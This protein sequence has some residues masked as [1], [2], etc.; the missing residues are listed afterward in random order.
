MMTY[1]NITY[2]DHDGID[3][4]VHKWVPENNVTVKGSLCIVHGMAEHGKRYGVLAERLTKEGYVVY[5]EDIRGHGQTMEKDKPGWL[6]DDG[7]N[8]VIKDFKQLIDIIKEEYPEKPVFLYGHSWGGFVA[9]DL[10]QQFGKHFKGVILSAVGGR[11]DLLGISNIVGKLVQLFKG[12]EAEAR[13]FYNLT[14]IPFRKPFKDEP[15]GNAWISSIKEEVKKYDDDPLCGFKPTNGFYIDSGKAMKRMWKAK[16]EEMIP[17]DLPMFFINSNLDPMT[18]FTKDMKILADR[19]K[20]LG[21]QN[22]EFKIYQNVRHEV[23]NDTTREE[24]INDIIS[25]LNKNA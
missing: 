25:F 1:T 5:A 20:K 21:I 3:I 14:V 24:V 17:K 6:G 23:L 7:W 2:K 8:N 12:K 16:S 22:L 11:Q 13:V 9:Q 18:N 4:F 19:Y 10:I 15:S